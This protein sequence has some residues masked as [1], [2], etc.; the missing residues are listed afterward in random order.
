MNIFIWFISEPSIKKI[1]TD[2]IAAKIL[3]SQYRLAAPPPPPPPAP[4][5]TAAPLG[6][7]N[8]NRTVLADVHNN[9]PSK[10]T[11]T[12]G[13]A[14]PTVIDA[15]WSD[16]EEF[17][18]SAVPQKSKCVEKEVPQLPTGKVEIHTTAVRGASVS[19]SPKYSTRLKSRPSSNKTA[20][21][22]QATAIKTI[23]RLDS[24]ES[25]KQ[26]RESKFRQNGKQNGSPE[27][28]KYHHTSS[29]TKAKAV[30][31]ASPDNSEISEDVT[32]VEEDEIVG[33]PKKKKSIFQRVRERL[34]ATF[35]RQ[36]DSEDEKSSTHQGMSV[37]STESGRDQKR[38][39]PKKAKRQKLPDEQTSS[40]DGLDADERK[41]SKPKNI[42]S[43]LQRRISS[44]RLKRSQS[45][46]MLFF[47]MLCNL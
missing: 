45:K 11:R 33:A 42:F 37:D 39:K 23:D 16:Y 4:P 30:P 12:A 43:T 34:N 9:L 47:L 6:N 8:T 24:L 32:D 22:T 26:P 1:E 15:N 3:D 25:P 28:S 7:Q 2:L 14:K 20:A 29:K 38:H 41:R 31:K 46:G 21:Q 10:F 5:A 19:N 27:Q 17:G 36:K 40:V 44:R 18:E 13:V 35:K